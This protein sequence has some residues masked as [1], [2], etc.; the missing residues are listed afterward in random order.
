ML[1]DRPVWDLC[2]DALG[3]W[4]IAAEPYAQAQDAASEARVFAGEAYYDTAIGVPYFS[5]VFGLAQPT[6]ILRAKIQEAALRVPGVTEAVA[7]VFVEGQLLNGQIQITSAA[8]Q[9]VIA[10]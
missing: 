6:Q 7:Y 9:Q 4:A 1:L 2:V 8:G 3:N 10:I 5:E